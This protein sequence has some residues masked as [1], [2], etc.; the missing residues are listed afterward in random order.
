MCAENS[1]QK[2]I[3]RISFIVLCPSLTIGGLSLD[4]STIAL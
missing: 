2:V 4:L 1:K 3:N